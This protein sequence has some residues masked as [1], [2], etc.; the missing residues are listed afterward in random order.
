MKKY[1]LINKFLIS[2]LL[3]SIVF[4]NLPVRVSSA[5]ENPSSNEKAVQLEQ[6]RAYII[7]YKNYHSGKKTLEGKS[8][9][10]TDLP[11]LALTTAVLTQEEVTQLRKN[12]DIAYIE[13]DQPVEMAGDIVTQNLNQIR[14]PE[15]HQLDLEGEGIK[16]AILDTGIDKESGELQLAGGISFVEGE[17]DYD[18]LHGHGTMVAGV[19]AALQDDAG[20]I[21]VAPKV[22]LY[23]VKVLDQGGVGTYSQVIAGIEWA[24]AHEMDIISMSFAG[25]GSSAALQEAVSYA[26]DH[27]IL[28]IGAA[29]NQSGA[30]VGYPA[31]Y[32]EVLS[33][34]AVDAYYQHAYFSNQGKIDLVAPGVHVM[35]LSLT[36]E[37]YVTASGTS[38]AVP[39][40]A[41][42]AALIKQ[43][44]PGITASD[45]KAVL[46]DGAI[47]LGSSLQYGHGLVSAAGSFHELGYPVAANPVHPEDPSASFG[48]ESDESWLALYPP[49]LVDSRPITED[50]IDDILNSNGQNNSEMVTVQET[51]DP[52]ILNAI[53]SMTVRMDEAPYA[54]D[55]GNEQIS[56]VSGSLSVSATDLY[57]P[58]RN[59][60]SFALTRTYST[61]DSQLYKSSYEP[62]YECSCAIVYNVIIFKDRRQI[63]A[64]GNVIQGVFR[65]YITN[66]N[67]SYDTQ[68]YGFM[69]DQV[70]ATEWLKHLKANFLGR[71]VEDPW[72]TPDSQGWQ[73]RLIEIRG[74]A[75]FIP[76]NSVYRGLRTK[77]RD[78]TALEKR[79]PIGKGWTW[80]I[81]YMEEVEGK[82]YL[83]LE[84]G[85]TYELNGNTIKDYP[86]QDMTLSNDSSVTVNGVMS[87]RKLTFVSGIKQYFDS[88]GWLI[89]IADAYNNT[90]K[91]EYFPH[92]QYGNVIS[93]ITDSAGNHI[94][95]SYSETAVVATQGDKTV[96]YHKSV[97]EREFELVPVKLKTE[98]LNAV[99]DAGGRQTEYVY[100]LATAYDSIVLST[101]AHN[102]YYLLKTVNHPT[103]AQTKYTYSSLIS[104]Y[105]TSLAFTQFFKLLSRQEQISGST[106]PYNQLNITYN[107]DAWFPPNQTNSYTVSMSDGLTTTT[108]YNRRVYFNDTTPDMYYTD[109]QVVTGGGTTQTTTFTYD[110]TMK[111]AFPLT[112]Q[113]VVAAGGVSSA[114][115]TM[116]TT[117]DNFGNVLT[118]TNPLDHMTTYGYNAAGLL[119]SVTSPVDATRSQFMQYTRNDKGKITQ[120]E[121]RQNDSSG[122]L[123]SQLFLEDID[124]ATGNVRRMRQ[125]DNDRN[126]IKTIEYSSAYQYAYPTQE[127]VVTK[128]NEGASQ[129]NKIIYEYGK[130]TGLVKK[131]TDGRGNVTSYLYDGLDR[132]TS[133]TNP[134]GSSRALH[135]S[136]LINRVRLTDETGVQSENRYNPIGW[137]TEQGQLIGSNFKR[138]TEMTYDSNGR[139]LTQSDGAGRTTT[140]VY[141][142]WGRQTQTKYG[143]GAGI[144]VVSTTSYDDVNRTQTVTDADANAIRTRMD[145]LGQ[146]TKVE[147]IRP[148]GTL[149]L[150][151]TVYDRAGHA[152]QVKD[153]KQQSTYYSLD[154]M[155]RLTGVTNAKGEQTGYTYSLLGM[156]THVAYPNGTSLSKKYDE[157]GRVIER[158]NPEDQHEQYTYDLSGNL[159][160]IIQEDGVAQ[161]FVYNNRNFLASK[162][163]PGET[164]SFSYDLAGRRTQMIDGTGMSSYTYSPTTGLLTKVKYPDN[165]EITYAY[166]GIGNR[167]QMTDPF[168][169]SQVYSYDQDRSLLKSV[170]INA[171]DPDVTYMYSDSGRLLNAQYRNGTKEVYT[172]Q[173]ANL[174]QVAHQNASQQ[175]LNT[176][177]YTYDNNRNIDGKTVN[178]QS[179][180]YSYDAL[181][182]IETDSEY[183]ATYSYDS[184]G[185]RQT[186]NSSQAIEI[187]EAE[188][189]YDHWNRLVKVKTAD[190]DEISYRYNGD[191]LLYE[192]N[193][194]GV[195]TRY[196]V[197]GADIIAEGT[198]TG[199]NA[200]Y[201]ASYIRGLGLAARQASDGS[202][203]YYLRDGHGDVVELR[204]E[205]GELKISYTYDI[206]G[207]PQDTEGEADNPFRYAGEYWDEA[208]GLQYL[209]ARW[210]DPSVG[211][212]INEDTFEG[213]IDNPLSLNLYTY[214]QNNPLIYID[215]TG[216]K[217]N[218]SI[219]NWSNI[220]R[221]FNVAGN[222]LLY[223]FRHADQGLIEVADFL[224]VDDIRTI[225]DP[226]AS[227]FDKTLAVA[228]FIPVGKVVK[229]GKIFIKLFNGEQEVVR[230]VDYSD[231]A[232][233]AV[234]KIPCNCFTAGTKVITDEGEK[235]IEDVEVGDKVLSK[236]ENTGE[237][238]YKE[239]TATFNH[240]TD[241]IYKIHVG[242]QVI[243][244]TFNHPFYVEGKGWTFVNDLKVGDLLVQSDENKLKID[245][246]EL[247]HKHVT[248]YNMTISQFHTYFV[249]DLGIWVHNTSCYSTFKN[250][251]SHYDTHVLGKNGGKREFGDDFTKDDYYNGAYNLATMKSDGTNIFRKTLSGGRV[252]TYSKTT[253]ELVII[254]NG[255]EVGT[256][257]KPKF[258]SSDPNAGF[259]YYNNLK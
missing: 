81:P 250:F 10:R 166:D 175:T 86:W 111:R 17:S 94:D 41:G 114:P 102:P 236:D 88:D 62:V 48:E 90:I 157:L 242:D 117:Y 60:L 25:T 169:Y 174:Q 146:I 189:E 161:S 45:L 255:S 220:K 197:D 34:G 38:V 216:H 122:P 43:A 235:N 70:Y 151:E 3:I 188:Y 212:F 258:G 196:Y 79:Y 230:A 193:E 218:L 194:N 245:S 251:D 65:D 9:R 67:Y 118:Q 24:V 23:A 200:Q 69:H 171:A 163:V 176:F 223:D 2:I 198:V 104:R 49:R 244:S 7:K 249:S 228:G 172:Y 107:G 123:L 253:N 30:S 148:G 211:R 89:Q 116:S 113:T 192:R 32:Q 19:L 54:V 233:K 158:T 240:E 78:T 204:N 259:N 128:N 224:V 234:S 93:K 213:Q 50:Q 201:K 239:V 168:G 55:M 221:A 28:L 109:K 68:N 182:R 95:I 190:G 203:N 173:N 85:A 101:A 99:T 51:S 13:P 145:V 191:N 22:Q 61:D 8:L 155:G 59:G 138:L 4:S 147:E 100:Q 110:E 56:T 5:Q 152:I 44:Q 83:H 186:L 108:H 154:V 75:E 165:R 164:I 132:V 15:V 141:D 205:A 180:S 18:D 209:R 183:T 115:I 137:L 103:G 214:V 237:V 238:A 14:V 184:V 247:E 226:N 112:E 46:L 76:N 40:V 170:G 12:K 105:T 144:K 74:D 20:L 207:N 125:T 82:S 162:S 257:F 208:T 1:S 139:L 206:W 33:V 210:Y 153:A 229:G 16:V 243:E 80:N 58:G 63:D 73:T 246:I 27:G 77:A 222:R 150:S 252:A 92:T 133:V 248:V 131:I 256:Y 215:P 21:G 57:L 134:D 159:S 143:I 120:I 127:T 31:A 232:W 195:I 227:T 140:Y 129:T 202:K 37:Q 35:G 126:V 71:T 26:S 219:Y 149:V 36:P 181:N 217:L 231:D 179:Y 130:P 199:G 136:D 66:F 167:Q 135:Y 52:N 124:P 97:L 53:R 6:S 160:S 225:F 39:H 254:H 177:G 87:S 241:E 91:F 106:V 72:S 11:Q 29:G 187:S 98:V 119:T 142:N 121:V 42:V 178:G 96:T 64:N 47:P 84:S 156:L 185:N